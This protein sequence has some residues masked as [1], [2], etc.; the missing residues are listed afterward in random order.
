M[1]ES[2]LAPTLAAAR[3]RLAAVDVAAY[4]GT[5]NHLQGA[6]TCLSPY[7]T[8]GLLTV[9][10]CLTALDLPPQHK[11]VYEFGWRAYFRHVWAH[12]GDAILQ[13]LHPGPLPDEAYAPQLPADIRRGAT[14]VPVIDQAVRTLYATGMLHNHARMWLA[15]Y[16]V[17]G[18][19]VHWRAAADWLYA[20]LLD[21]DLASNHLSWQWV[22]AT[23]SHKPYVFDA[24]NVARFAPLAWH[25]WG[26]A[27]DL[28]Y[29]AW[30]TLARRAE[31]LPAGDGAGVDEP[32]LQ[33][34]PAGAR[35]PWPAAGPVWLAHPWALGEP[36]AGSA[37]VAVVIT[38][39]H[40][41]FPWSTRR[42]GWVLA[43]MGQLS[44]QLWVGSAGE[45]AAALAGR[46]AGAAPVHTLGNPHID[47]WLPAGVHVTPE[48]Q[49][50]PQLGTRCDSFSRWWKCVQG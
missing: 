1:I 18:R 22:A 19:K 47:R 2:G 33:H 26:S 34:H 9:P 48:P 21:G 12:R 28:S 5:R 49:H 6:V 11:L 41:A 8:H 38:D 25:S 7:I 30:D 14:G 31:A 45:L 27:V 15:S 24:A 42:W 46:P 10:A 50:F 36:P 16:V 4:A 39:A 35:P 17:H 44:G 3:A 37:V 43:R 29:E 32:A 23:G 13:S 20:H 40:A